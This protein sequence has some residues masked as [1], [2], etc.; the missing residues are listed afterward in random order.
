MK[1]MT[2]AMITSAEEVNLSNYDLCRRGMTSTV[3]NS[4]EEDKNL[5]R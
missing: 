3:I 5:R 2:S 4:V 1:R